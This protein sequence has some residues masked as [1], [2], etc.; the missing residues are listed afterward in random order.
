MKRNILFLFSSLLFAFSSFAQPSDPAGVTLSQPDPAATT[1]KVDWNDLSNP[2]DAGQEDGFAV[3]VKDNN[4]VTVDSSTVSAST[5]TYTTGTLAA[6]TYNVT[7]FAYQRLVAPFVFSN[8]AA[9]GPITINDVNLAVHNLSVEL[10]QTTNNRT[11]MFWDN[12]SSVNADGFRLTLTNLSTL[13]TQILNFP[14]G[15]SSTV[16]NNLTG[17]TRYSASIYAYSGVTNGPS[18]VT[19]YFTTKPN[20]PLPP[21][22]ELIQNCPKEI[23]L[24]INSPDVDKVEEYIL[25]KA[26]TSNGF[27]PIFG[28]RAPYEP[29]FLDGEENENQ[30]V[31]TVY[32][33]VGARNVTGITYSQ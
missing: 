11:F 33:R 13:Q 10:E 12:T 3:V 7:V 1:I 19:Q 26:Y 5:I 2:G 21:T 23:L 6:G 14:F 24:K 8:S 9:A 29:Y 16:I 15:T 18:S 30:R 28:T 4:G 31:G 27:G 20:A 32:Y 22:L 25:Q 17:S